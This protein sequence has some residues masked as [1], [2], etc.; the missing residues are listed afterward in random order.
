[1]LRLE[2]FEIGESQRIVQ[3]ITE[4][5]VERFALISGDMNPLHMDAAFAATTPFG[6]RVSHGM[7]TAAL[8]SAAHTSLTGPG[9]V[10][11]GQDLKFLA[12]VFIGDMLTV[13]VTVRG[14]R[15]EKRMLVLETSVCKQDGRCVLQGSSALKELTAAA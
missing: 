4:D 5:D 7:L 6:R 13:T 1:M 10:Y 9:F 8:V 3:T 14:K 15:A 12:P 2:D 11:V